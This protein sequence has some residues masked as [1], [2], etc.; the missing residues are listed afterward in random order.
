MVNPL[1]TLTVRHIGTRRRLIV[2][3]GTFARVN[4]LPPES[5]NRLKEGENDAILKVR[6]RFE[7]FGA[8]WSRKGPFSR[9][10]A[11]VKRH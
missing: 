11:Y 2:V 3:N 6:G 10:R 8:I 7:G 5:L 1:I 4:P 9:A